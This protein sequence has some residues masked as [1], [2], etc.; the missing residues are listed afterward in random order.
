MNRLMTVNCLAN[1]QGNEKR[2]C[3]LEA[4][5][6]ELKSEL[7]KE[8][9]GR[10]QENH[11]KNSKNLLLSLVMRKPVFRV[12]DQV[13]LKPA[14]SAKDASWSHEIAN[15]ETRDIIL[16][17]QRTTKVLIRLCRCAG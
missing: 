3:M 11:H 6:N 14:C 15:I 10:Y 17:R 16:T 13:R 12:Y 7:E 1:I 8:A 2:V 4:K 5:Y 9:D